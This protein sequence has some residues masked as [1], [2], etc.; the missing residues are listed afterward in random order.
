MT[1]IFYDCIKRRSHAYSYFNLFV[2]VGSFF[3]SIFSGIVIKSYGYKYLFLT[4]FTVM[5]FA[6]I[7]SYFATKNINQKLNTKFSHDKKAVFSSSK[8]LVFYSLAFVYLLCCVSYGIV[9]SGTLTLYIKN[10]CDRDV[11]G[12][13]IPATWFLML[14]SLGYFLWV[15]VVAYSIKYF[16]KNAKIKNSNP[17]SI[18]NRYCLGLSFLGLGFFF[19]MLSSYRITNLHETLISPLYIIMYFL[20]SNI[21]WVILNPTLQTAASELIPKSKNSTYMGI[22]SVFM[23][24]GF[25]LGSWLGL[26]SLDVGKFVIFS[27]LTIALILSSLIIFLLKNSIDKIVFCPSQ[28]AV[29]QAKTS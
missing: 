20:I 3:A 12:F 21:G 13:E 25:Y 10:Y 2:N 17:F 16:R 14:D 7:L 1:S 4:C 24:I 6:S 29:E 9:T 11:G 23:G 22:Y 18:G 19:L 28:V 5:L 15:P 26:A 8:L 27:F